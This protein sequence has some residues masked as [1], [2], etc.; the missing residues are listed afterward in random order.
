MSYLSAF[1]LRDVISLA[2]FSYRLVR[3]SFL[4][5]C[6]KYILL[7]NEQYIPSSILIHIER[8]DREGLFQCG[9]SGQ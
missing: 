1:A 7:K 2:L 6:I 8:C 5:C 4:N 9:L 3:S